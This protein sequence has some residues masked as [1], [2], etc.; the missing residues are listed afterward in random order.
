MYL[1]NQLSKYVRGRLLVDI[2]VAGENTRLG[3]DSS[4]ALFLVNYSLFFAK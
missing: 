3:S 4:S 1:E 2:P